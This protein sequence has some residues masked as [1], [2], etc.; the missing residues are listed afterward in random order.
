MIAEYVMVI[1][2][3]VQ[4]V[5]VFPMEMVLHAMENVDHVMMRL[6]KVRVIVMEI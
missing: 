5:A 3:P 4:T 2:Q 1:I 6:M